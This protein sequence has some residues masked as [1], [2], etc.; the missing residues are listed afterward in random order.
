[1]DENILVDL[2]LSK[3]EAKIYITL[4]QLGRSA[5]TTI[6]NTA[7][8]HRANVYDSLKKLVD[9]GLAS[10]MHQEKSTY[11]EASNPQA[12]ELIIKEKENKLKTI[13]P[14]LLLQKQMAEKKGE[15]N[16]FEGLSALFN[17]LYNFLHYKEDIQVYGIPASVPEIVRTKINHYHKERLKQKVKMLH[18]YNHNAKKRIKYLNQMKLTYARFLPESFDSQVSTFI[19]GEEILLVLW[20]PSIV[21]IR[22]KNQQIANAYKKYFSLLWAAAKIR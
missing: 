19:C 14:Q 18:I 11:Y 12:L 21:I 6:A 20:A 7:K 5:V 2:G 22:V 1:M 17:Q 4:L 16:V 15:A 10:Y 3:S 13:M 8:L 9:K